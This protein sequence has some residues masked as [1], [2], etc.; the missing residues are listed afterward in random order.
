MPVVSVLMGVKDAPD[1]VE[2]AVRS[3]L[4]QTFS[5]LELIVVD[6]GSEDATPEVL[7]AIGDARLVVL[8]N[9]TNLG[10]TRSLNR[11]L[12]VARGEFVARQDADDRSLPQRLE[13]QLAHMR[14][15]PQVGICGAWTRLVDQRGQVV[16]HGRN[17]VTPAE[18]AE[19]MRQ[20]NKI[21]HGTLFARRAVMEAL[22]GYRE[23]FR[24]SQDYDLLLRA[25]DV[26]QLANVPEELYEFRVHGGS[27]S[28]TK[29]DTQFRLRVLARDLAAQ[30]RER[31]SDDLDDGVPVDELVARIGLDTYEYWAN[32]ALQTRLMGDLR[33]YRTA[34]RRMIRKRPASLSPYAQLALSVGGIRTLRAAQ[35]M[36]DT[37]GVVRR[38][39]SR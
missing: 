23:A 5:E 1:D 17:P 36:A 39:H 10:L 30:R 25:L 9:E 15:H 4:D 21:F 3:I 11:A 33:G 12:G 38:R 22:G 28:S 7:G 2:R 32:R 34:L 31:G 16:G 14:A 19:G 37:A 35:A 24:Y 26:T 8:R 6:D 29:T 20:D 18:V 27:L 13:R